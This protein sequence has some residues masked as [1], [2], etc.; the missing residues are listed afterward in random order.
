MLGFIGSDVRYSGKDIGTMS[1]TAFNTI[2]MVDT[3]LS[4]FFINIK[5]SEIIVKIYGSSA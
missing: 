1:S 5:M 3:T 4:G 2:T